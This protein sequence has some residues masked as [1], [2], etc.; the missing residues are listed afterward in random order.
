MNEH[1]AVMCEAP[2]ASAQGH[3]IAQAQ[4]LGLRQ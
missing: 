1:V 4:M 3:L 2:K